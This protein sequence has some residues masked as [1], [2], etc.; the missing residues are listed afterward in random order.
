[1]S[2]ACKTCKGKGRFQVREKFSDGDEIL[3]WY[4]C[5]DCKGTGQDQDPESADDYDLGADEDD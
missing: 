1:M 2:K 4:E 5:N 3:T